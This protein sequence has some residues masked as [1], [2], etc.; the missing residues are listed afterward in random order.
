MY[1][2]RKVRISRTRLKTV[3]RQNGSNITKMCDALNL[4]YGT[5][6]YCI[7]RGEIMPDY[8]ELISRYTG[9]NEKYLMEE[10]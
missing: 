3:L 2:K 4:N 1:K 6:C 7:Q 8:L 5:I 9:I 10:G